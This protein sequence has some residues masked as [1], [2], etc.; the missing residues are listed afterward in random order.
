MLVFHFASF[1]ENSGICE[2]Y[3][4]Q[5][6]GTKVLF[7]RKPLYLNDGWNDCCYRNMDVTIHMVLESKGIARFILE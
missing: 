1:K 6:S 3:Q 4:T 5:T 2:H 7:T